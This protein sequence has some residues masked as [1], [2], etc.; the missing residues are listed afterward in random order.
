MRVLAVEVAD[1]GVEASEPGGEACR[2]P[3]GLDPGLLDLDVRLAVL[4]DDRDGQPCGEQI[5]DVGADVDLGLG[6]GKPFRC[7]SRLAAARKAGDFLRV[8]GQP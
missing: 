1:A 4:D 3:E 5:V 6:Q 8:F 2:Q 7:W